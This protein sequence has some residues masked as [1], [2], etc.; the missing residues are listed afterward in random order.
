MFSKL[1]RILL[2]SG[3][4]LAGTALMGPAAFA[5]GGAAGAVSYVATGAANIT[6][7]STAAAT[8][9]NGATAWT[10]NDGANTSAGSFGSVG[11]I[12]ITDWANPAG[13]IASVANAAATAAVT[14]NTALV[15]G[16]QLDIGL[17]PADNVVTIP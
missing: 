16:P 12:T 10:F 4:A 5:D 13:T 14:G 2:A 11:V 6:T 17:A 9:N 15:N 8:G 3:L 1:N 7:L